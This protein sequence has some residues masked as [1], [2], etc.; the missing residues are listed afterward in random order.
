MRP[1][2]E[3]N[4]AALYHGD[5]RDVLPAVLGSPAAVIVAD[6][7][8]GETS[9]GWDHWPDGWPKLFVGLAPQLWCFG[10]LRMFLA[11]RDEFSEWRYGQE[12]VWEKHNGSIFHADRFRRV[13]E[14]ATHW[15]SGK[16]SSLVRNTQY[17]NEVTK[18][19]VRRKERPA[20]TG[21]I[22]NSTYTSYDGGPRMMRS[23]LQ[24]RSEHGRAAHPT[25]KP[26]DIIR[27]LVRYSS[28]P[29]DVVADPFAGAGSVMLAAVQD[30]R[31]A[32]GV[33]A[34]ERYCEVTARRLEAALSGVGPEHEE[35]QAS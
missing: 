18:K 11:H 29:G 3:G 8:Y 22:A 24:V 5:A 21:Y 14:I 33:E 23:V 30:G 34:D 31:R 27:P 12:I 17:T 19:T 2:Y 15:Y 7:P 9:L 6:P 16:W 20:H 10:S 25:Q 28:R 13:H 4:G 32:V 1:Y 26:L 35:T